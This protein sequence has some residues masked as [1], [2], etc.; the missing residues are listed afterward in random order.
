MAPSNAAALLGHSTQ[1]HLMTYVKPT[2]E[3]VAGAGAALASV[4]KAAQ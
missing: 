4:V 3:G 1:M 2:Q